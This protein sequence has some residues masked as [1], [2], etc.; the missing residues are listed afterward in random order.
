MAQR[1]AF[2]GWR[3]KRGVLRKKPEDRFV[4]IC[5]QLTV[6]S[7]ANEER[8]DALADRSDVMF[9]IGTMRDFA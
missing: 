2:F 5:N 8:Y 7:N 9:D 3:A 1:D 4:D 6:E